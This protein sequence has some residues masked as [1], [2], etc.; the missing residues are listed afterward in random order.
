M[1]VTQSSAQQLIELYTNIYA[2]DRSEYYH[3]RDAETNEIAM[4]VNLYKR[5]VKIYMDY[6]RDIHVWVKIPWENAFTIRNDVLLVKAEGIETYSIFA[7]EVV[8]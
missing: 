4:E 8:A 6:A 1:K 7:M 3:V 2:Q 5:Y